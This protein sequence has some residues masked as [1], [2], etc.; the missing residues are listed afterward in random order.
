M[1]LPFMAKKKEAMLEEVMEEQKE[2][3]LLRASQLPNSFFAS[4]YQLSIDFSLLDAYD[5][6]VELDCHSN[7]FYEQLPAMAKVDGL[8]FY[9][10][11]AMYHTIELLRRK[12]KQVKAEEMAQALFDTYGFSEEEKK[13]FTLLLA[14]AFRFPSQFPPL[15]AK[16]FGRYLFDFS[17]ESPFALAFLENFCYNSYSSFQTYLSK[18]ISINRRIRLSQMER[19]PIAR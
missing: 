7:F 9:K 15:F 13:L 17:V 11:L 10:I 3:L 14:C 6:F 5:F 4:F 1:L 12:R 8:R 18:Y 16:S 19:E 2:A